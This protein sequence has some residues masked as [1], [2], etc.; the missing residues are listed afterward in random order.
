LGLG[1]A[2]VRLAAFH[3]VT[4]ALWSGD[5]ENARRLAADMTERALTVG[6]EHPQGYA[7]CAQAHVWAWLGQ[8]E[9]AQVAAEEAAA[10]FTKFGMAAGALYAQGLLGTLALSVGDHATAARWLAPAAAAIVE[11]GVAE[12]ACFPFLPDAAEALIALGRLDE[13]E[14]LVSRLE[15]SGRGPDRT[16]AQAVGARTRGLLAAADSDLDAARSAF[17]RALVVHDR[18]LLPHERGRT[19]LALGQLQRRRN[20]RRAAGVSLREAARAFDAVSAV[21]WADNARAELDR[22]GVRPGPVD[23][24]TPTEERVAELA[25]S[26]LTN[27]EVA[28]ALV[29]SPKTVEANLSRVYRK[30]GIRSRAQLGAWLA[31]RRTGGHPPMA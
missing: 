24:L 14:P 11:A 26:G 12:P 18:L 30:L 21:R 16:W 1:R 3:A 5:I 9:E 17:E 27:R 25:A 10:I 31:H 8:V 2:G 23:H 13:A 29:V 28:A 6:T 15:A 22:L 20:E 7:L 19:L 4:A